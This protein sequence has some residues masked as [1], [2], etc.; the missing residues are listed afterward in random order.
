MSFFLNRM[1]RFLE[2][3]LQTEKTEAM[4]FQSK[5]FWEI[6]DEN[7]TNLQEDEKCQELYKTTTTRDTDGRY[8]VQIPFKEE[9][10]LGNSR[11]QA[12]A[13]LIN[14]EKKMKKEIKSEYIEFM[15]E[16]ERLGHM[17]KAENENEGLYYMPHQAVIREA[18]STTKLRV[19][20]DASAKTT[21]GNSLNNIMMTG[22]RLQ[23]DIFDIIIKWRLWKFVVT[24]DVEKMYRQIKI[25]EEH[26]DYQ[27][28]YGTASAPFLAV[29]T[30]QQIAEDY[31]GD[32]LI[33]NTI[34]DDFYMDDLLTGADTK[35]DCRNKTNTI[36][37][38]LSSAGFKLRKWMSNNQS[39]LKNLPIDAENKILCIEEDNSIKTLGLKWNPKKDEFQFTINILSNE[40]ITKRM[41]LS[42][43]AKMFDPL[44]E[45]IRIPRW[46]GV[47]SS[48][49]WE[50]HGFSDASEAA[51]AA[52][53]YI[54]IGLHINLLTAKSKVAPIKNKKT[55]PKLELCG[56]HL[57]AKLMSKIIKILNTNPKTYC[58]SDSAITLWWLKEPKNKEK[59]VRTRAT[60]IKNLIPETE[61]RHI[62]SKD[63][64]ADIAPRGICANKLKDYMLW[65]HGPAWLVKPKEEW[66]NDEKLNG[67]STVITTLISDNNFLSD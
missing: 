36:F 56:A 21:N 58:W 50:L 27:L 41:V 57:L 18:S 43:Y 55:I 48:D 17:V 11:K 15:R 3:I 31:N 37:K 63:N 38:C 66:P 14:L 39:I 1:K 59:F 29:R 8:M 5:R 51:Y 19:V 61:W 62:R 60:E 44:V 23:K 49:N 20:F 12:V 26:Q 30:L 35:L 13:R 2:L 64:P 32:I 22:P 46:M 52:V 65:W 10:S 54:K 6:D 67:M 45:Q 7:N 53:I 34:K 47:S 24:A 9:L 40:K 16:Y 42:I 4:S 25:A 28:T 33:K